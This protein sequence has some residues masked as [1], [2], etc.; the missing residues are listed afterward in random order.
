MIKEFYILGLYGERDVRINFNE[1]YKI[2]V[3][4]NGYGKTTILNL[5]YALLFGDISKLRR[6]FFEEI[7]VVFSNGVSVNFVKDEFKPVLKSFRNSP[8]YDYLEDKLGE[9]YIV[10]LIED[11]SKYPFSK[12]ELSPRFRNARDIANVPAEVFRDFL[13]EARHGD[14]K[15]LISA[16]TEAKLANIRKLFPLTPLYLP[17]Y[18]RVEEDVKGLGGMFDEKALRFTSINFGMEDVKNS[19]NRI[20]SEILSSSVEWFSKINGEMLSQL[21]NGFNVTDEMKDSISDPKAVRIVLERI[22]EHISEEQKLKILN[23][24][25]SGDIFIGHDP[26]IYFVANLLKVYKQQQIN[27]NAIQ[28][29]T[30]VSNKYLRDKEVVYNESNVTIDIIRKKNASLVDI[31]TLSSGEKQIIS[32]FALLYLKNDTNL[33]IFFDEPELSLSIEWQKTLLPDILDSGKCKFLFCTTHS[34]FIFDNELQTNTV[35]LGIY[36]T[37]R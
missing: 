18:R 9:S 19:I 28:S 12:M 35:D 11:V 15:K 23:L 34:P 1:Q 37:E 16:K 30:S 25:S 13:R 3:A 6:M 24:V 26:L 14:F 7:G 20:T 21:V 33:A 27:D 31:E 5:F 32:L 29:F 10:E 8:F 2:I 36:T 4:E 17:T 22:G